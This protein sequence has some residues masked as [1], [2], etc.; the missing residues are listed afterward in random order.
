[1]LN[2]RAA[3][4]FASAISSRPIESL[5]DRRLFAAGDL[6]PSFGL[7]GQASFTLEGFAHSELTVVDV[8]NGRTVL[9]G[10]VDPDG[11]GPAAARVALAVLDGGGNPVKSFSGDG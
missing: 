9:G 3:R 2:H 10:S 7:A 4:R 11:D 5:E 1:M 6:D 8:A